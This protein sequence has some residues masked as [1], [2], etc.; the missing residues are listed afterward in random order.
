MKYRCYKCGKFI[1]RYVRNR[2]NQIEEHYEFREFT[3]GRKEP[4]YAHNSCLPKLP[5]PS[6]HT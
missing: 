4:E 6:F 3:F 2:F 1:K 5:N